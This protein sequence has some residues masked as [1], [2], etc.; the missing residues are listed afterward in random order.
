MRTSVEL[1]HRKLYHFSTQSRHHLDSSTPCLIRR[2]QA[3][4]RMR[5]SDM[6]LKLTRLF[7]VR[8]SSPG[9]LNRRLA[10]MRLLL[11]T[12]RV[13]R[14]MATY[15][16]MMRVYILGER[17][18]WSAE[19]CKATSQISRLGRALALAQT[20]ARAPSDMTIHPSFE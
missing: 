18:L 19:F 7:Q 17:F 16:T 3:F 2:C 6:L 13:C 9:S 8:P 5:H 20:G 11:L 15:P 12:I 14:V 1:R 4:L 10:L